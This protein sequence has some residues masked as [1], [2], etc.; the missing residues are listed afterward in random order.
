MIYKDHRFLCFSLVSAAILA[1]FPSA[2][3]AELRSVTVVE[4]SS[5][6][7]LVRVNVGG[8]NGLHTGDPVLFSSTTSKIAAGRVVQVG[9]ATAVI[10]VMEKYASEPPQINAEYD[11]LYGEPFAE[12]ANL[13]DFVADRELERDNPKNEKF[14][15]QDG[16]DVTPELDDDS[17]TPEVSIRPKFP[18][19]RTFSPHNITV[20][21]NVFRNRAL[22]TSVAEDGTPVSDGYTTYNGYSIRYA[23]VF[24]SNYWFRSHA[25]TLIS[26]EF[27]MGVY[28]FTHTFPPALR[29]AD[30]DDSTSVRVIPLQGE[31]RYLIELSKLFRVYPY[32]GYQYNIVGAGK[33]SSKGL[34][35]LTGGRLLGGVGAQLVM[36]D[37][38]DTRL[39]AGSDGVL[40]GLVVKF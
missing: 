38:L 27:G 37:T 18:A 33:G 32:L 5:S 35:P 4:S 29:P 1:S 22:P 20:G 36:S 12:A 34:E 10:A 11:L 15:E 19:S 17:Y 24:R 9:D 7:K 2:A 26:A 8:S 6:G 31:L 23:Y 14:W 13:P 39:E 25:S 28:S 21:L 40:A 3:N 30:G 16:R